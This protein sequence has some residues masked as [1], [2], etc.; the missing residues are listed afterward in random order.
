MVKLLIRY[1]NY[2]LL[3][4][5]QSMN[6]NVYSQQKIL[7]YPHGPA[8]SNQ[9]T[10]SEINT[11]PD[12][13][14]RIAEPRMYYYPVK[15]SQKPVPAVLICPGGG[16]SG[17]SVIKEGEEIARWFNQRNYAAFVLYYRMPNGHHQIPLKDALTAMTIIRKKSGVWNIDPKQVGI[18]GF[19][20]GGHLA[21]TVGT[22]FSS[23]KNRPDFMILAYPVI[24][25]KKQIS[26]GGS[27][28]NL[29]GSK[30]DTTLVDLYSNELQVKKKT[31]PAFIFHA[32]DDKAVP[33][34][35]SQLMAEGLKA[36]KVPVEL[37]IFQK[38]G[39]GFGMRPVDPDTDR[40]PEYLDVWLKNLKKN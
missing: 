40:W 39:H 28:Q 36:A 18:M 37:H 7:L 5:L 25:M 20:A 22:H 9:F 34:A 14:T 27:R 11:R 24:S 16:Y 31:P 38:G 12:F 15:D 10:E 32:V 21:S 17:V 6:I 13:V 26:H 23:T 8:E 35:N 3:F 4:L 30:P 19:S 29:L 2:L 1:R 33:V